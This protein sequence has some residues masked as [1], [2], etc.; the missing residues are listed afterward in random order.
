MYIVMKSKQNCTKVFYLNAIFSFEEANHKGLLKVITIFCIKNL[1]SDICQTKF[2]KQK[3]Q[4]PTCLLSLR[5]S[6]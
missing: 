2:R 6:V 1:V 5:V 3:R 4:T